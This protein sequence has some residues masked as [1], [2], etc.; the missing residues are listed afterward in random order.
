MGVVV[1]LRS[2]YDHR[3]ENCS[4]CPDIILIMFFT[5]SC[6]NPKPF[7]IT[8]VSTHDLTLPTDVSAVIKQT[9][10]IECY[11]VTSINR[12]NVLLLFWLYLHYHNHFCFTLT[13]LW[14]VSCA[15]VVC[16]LKY[17][18]TY[19]RKRKTAFEE[20]LKKVFCWFL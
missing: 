3:Y 13:I 17:S 16:L 10:F 18:L 11:S 19:K 9:L 12:F 4:S 7:S 8:C 2:A 6:H 14:Y 15:F 5:A 1:S 20:A